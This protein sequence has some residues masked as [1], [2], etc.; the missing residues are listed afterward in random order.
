MKIAWVT[1][2]ARR[3]AIGRVSAAIVKALRERDHEILVVRSERERADADAAHPI[4]SS[5]PIV[6]WNDVSPRDVELQNDAVVLNFGDNYN[7]HAGTLAFVDRASCL[8]IFHD[9]YLYNLFNRWLAYQGLGEDIHEREVRCTY[10]EQT[11]ELARRAWRGTAPV[12]ELAEMMPMTE[13]LASRCGAALAHSRFYIRRLENSCPGPIAV[14]PLCYESRGIN[15]LSRRHDHRVTIAIIGVINP[16]KCVD[17]VIRS[18]AS[19]GVLRAG[20]RV[21][22]VGAIDDAERHRIE[23]LCDET[24]FTEV[25]ILGEVD[26]AVLVKELDGADILSCLREPVLEGA[27]ASAIEGMKAGRPIVVADVGFYSDLP[28]DLVFKIPTPVTV[29]KLTQVLERLVK[30]ENLRRDTAA[31]AQRWALRTFTTEGYVSILE[32]LT[33]KYI[34][35]KP[36]LAAG[37][38]I[39]HQL[40]ALG[41]SPGDPSVEQL[42]TKLELLFSPSAINASD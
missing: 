30:D 35:A 14:A 12:E 13:W 7:F 32:D 11:C 16:N 8:G 38:R 18:I 31:Q 9:F 6:W 42:A 33:C 23:Q 3:S 29:A 41:T 26:D 21:R 2:L 37:K 25:S 34:S 10:G 1:P 28:D 27:S 19:S 24:G 36:L 20:C 15:L 4:S 5:V 39:A 40:A 17:A 22:L